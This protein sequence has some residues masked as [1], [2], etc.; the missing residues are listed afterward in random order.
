M[1][2]SFRPLFTVSVSHGYFGGPCRPFTYLTPT[3]ISSTLAAARVL[4][5]QRDGVL[6][7]LYGADA[8]GSPFISLDG[9]ALRFGLGLEMPHFANFT[10]LPTTF[11]QRALRYTNGA[12]PNALAQ[13]ASPFVVGPTFT[14]SPTRAD[15]P[16]T[17]DLED[18]GGAFA[19]R[20][21]VDGDLS[22][23]FDLRGRPT[24]PFTVE[25]TYAG[26]SEQVPCYLD[27]ELARTRVAGLVEIVVDN[28]FYGAA[29]GFEISFD[30][31]TEPLRYYLVGKRHTPAE[32]A[33]L[34]VADKGFGED[35]RPQVLFDL[36][37]PAGFGP[38]ELDPS[39]I[40][41]PD[42]AVVLFRSK[43]AIP[44]MHRGRR[45]IELSRKTETLVSNL[46]QPAEHQQKTEVIVH[47]SKP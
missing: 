18:A 11:P 27:E 8:G 41:S 15:R 14:H 45:R 16:V 38:D 23:S 4:V 24:G 5:R 44:R 3:D 26:G 46:P 43:S 40:S 39:L 22:T 13:V 31:C 35:G 7:V 19:S 34:G 1:R 29:P 10:Q 20:T 30:A 33:Q 17:L 37:L 6:H 12:A 28:A 42:D 47:V 25:E 2:L 21:L 9:V 32:A 36:V